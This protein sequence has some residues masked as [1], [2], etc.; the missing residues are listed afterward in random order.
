ME[1][2]RALL[3]P[4]TLLA[5][6]DPFG[7]VVPPE[8]TNR[9]FVGFNGVGPVGDDLDRLRL[10]GR[11]YDLEHAVIAERSAVRAF[12]FGEGLERAALELLLR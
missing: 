3:Q 5:A 2:F 7:V 1:R 9:L 4:A 6:N 12:C 11:G 8:A 10:L